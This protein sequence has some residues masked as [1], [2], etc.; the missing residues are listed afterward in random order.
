MQRKTRIKVSTILAVV[1]GLL[2]LGTVQINF[3]PPIANAT[4]LATF[5]DYELNRAKISDLIRKIDQE[6]KQK[7]L[8]C[9][10]MNIYHEAR[11]ESIT[12]QRA[13]AWVT[14]NRTKDSRY[15]NTI[16][17]V[18]YQ[19]KTE[20]HWRTGEPVPVKHQCQFSWYCDG[21]SDTIAN[22]ERW[23][24][25]QRIANM[26][27]TNFNKDESIDPTLGAVMYHATWMNDYPHWAASYKRSVRIDNHL[28]YK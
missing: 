16:C 1:L 25:A 28:F 8:E 21:K 17:D 4:N 12:G 22:L 6:E 5:N 10:A 15:P 9:L 18:V 3:R 24:Q 14:L 26:V 13:V 7:Q 27:W 19:A 23:E 2:F 20:P 11:S